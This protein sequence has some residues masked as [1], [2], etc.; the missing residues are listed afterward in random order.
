MPPIFLCGVFPS[1]C[2]TRLGCGGPLFAL[3]ACGSSLPNAK[4]A[5]LRRGGRCV[6]M[7]NVR[8]GERVAMTVIDA[9]TT[10]DWTE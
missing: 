2:L 5:L 9:D 6:D 3:E 1:S 7:V 8:K 4:R 10:A